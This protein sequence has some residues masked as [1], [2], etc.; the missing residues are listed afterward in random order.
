MV[1]PEL[2]TK[3][4]AAKK[5][6]VS[7]RR[8]ME[9]GVEGRIKRHRGYDPKTKREAVMFDPREV[10]AL[11]AGGLPRPLLGAAPAMKALPPGSPELEEPRPAGTRRRLW[12]TIEDAADITGLPESFLH[13]LVE[14]GRLPAFD[15]GVRPGGRLRIKRADLRE[16]KSDKVAQHGA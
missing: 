4:L 15:V 9:W 12:V 13:K 1:K 14:L 10:D 7:V 5:L 3:E 11:R 16:L 2:M 6:N 8:L